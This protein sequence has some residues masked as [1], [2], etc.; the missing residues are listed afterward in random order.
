MFHWK[1]V[2]Q[3]FDLSKIDT[4]DWMQEQAQNP[5][6]LVLGDSV[7]VYF[8]TRAKRDHEG[9]S[10]SLPGYVDFDLENLEKIV[11]IS[12]QPI[13]SYGGLG[14]FD[15]FG[16]MAG[17]IAEVENEI[18]L[19]YVGWTRKLSIPYNWAIGLGKS[20]DGG[21]TFLKHGRGPVIGPSWN[22]PYLQAGCSAIMNIDGTYHMWYTSGIKWIE[23]DSKPE[24]QY[25]I[26]H[27]TSKDGVHW[28]RNGIPVIE[29]IV[30][31][32][33]QASPTIVHLGDKWH[34]FFSYRYSTDFRNSDRG[35]RLGYAFSTDLITWTRDD[36]KVGIDVSEEGWDS[37]MICYPHLKIIKDQV[38]LFYCG[39]DFGKSGFGL[40]ILESYDE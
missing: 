5:Y 32:E 4:P 25:Q 22:E 28:E 37:E 38:H 12:D 21:K 13:V 30:E 9:K 6:A 1:K 15:E 10:K 29:A 27:A 39:N 8:N 23:T 33:A 36:T 11:G 24:S 17:S 31:N 20:K 3:I 7:R 34:M 14:D 16:V 40:A 19:Y 26:M 35:Y 18:C 2:G